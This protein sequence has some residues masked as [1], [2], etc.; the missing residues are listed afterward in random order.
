MVSSPIQFNYKDFSFLSLTF[1]STTLECFKKTES[2]FD[3]N[4]AKSVVCYLLILTGVYDKHQT[5]LQG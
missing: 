5:M 2:L 4:M 3:A 1:I